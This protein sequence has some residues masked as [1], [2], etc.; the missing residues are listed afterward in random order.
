M[1]GE[2]LEWP[3]VGRSGEL[4]RL[5]RLVSDGETPGV[6][7]AG[8]AGV[9]KTR[10]ALECVRLADKAGLATVRITATRAAAAL[11][12]GALA[13]LLPAGHHGETGGVDDRGDL[14]RRSAAALVERGG[15][16]RLV[17]FLDDAHSLDDASATLIHQLASTNAAFVLATLRVGDPAPEPVVAL[18]KDELV[19]R[20]DLVGLDAGAIEELLSKILGGT[21]D[22]ATVAQL[23]VR[24][25]GNVLFLRELVLGALEDGSLR[26]DGGIWRLAGYPGPSQRLIELVEAR[27]GRL[28]AAG[29]HLL[30]LV[31]YGEPL[32]PAHLEALTDP[33]LAE[34]LERK[35]LL[36]SRLD[37]HRVEVRLA[38]PLYGEVLRSRISALRLP[39]IAR[40]LAE[41]VEGTGARRREDTLRVG[42]WRL[43]GGGAHPELMLTAAITARWRYDFPLAERLAA[44]GVEAG[45]GFDAA[46]LLAQL[47]CL[48]GRPGEAERMLADLAGQATD[49]AQRGLVA[50][51]QLD[52]IG[53]YGGRMDEA[54]KLAEEAESAIADPVWR[55]EITARKAVLVLGCDGPRAA[56]EVVDPLLPTAQGR[57]LAWACL[58]ASFGHGRQGHVKAA[59]DASTLGYATQTSLTQPTD[60]YPLIHLWCRCEA[61][62]HAGRFEEAEALAKEQYALG[63]AEGSG[64]A[65]AWFCWHLASVVGERGNVRTAARYARESIASYRELGRPQF[66]RESLI[67]LALALALGQQA[68][69]ATEALKTLDALELPPTLYKPV[70][71]GLARA[72]TAVAAGDLPG[73]YRLLDEAA[74]LGHRIGDLVGE[75]SALHGLARLGRPTRDVATRL[76]NLAGVIEGNLAPARACHA[77]ALAAGD[78]EGLA[79]AS[80]LFES[81]GAHLLAAEAAADA[82]VTLRKAGDPRK[83]AA[84]ERRA[85]SLA[86]G[87]E[88]A[89]TP[90]LQAGATRAA[91]TSGE[92]QT[93][94]LAAAGRS[95]KQIAEELYVSVRT[96]ENQLQRVYEKLGITS[97][98]QLAEALGTEPSTDPDKRGVQDGVGN[99]G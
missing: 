48:Q 79:Q 88:G 20:I 28:D 39:G 2:K 62:A 51:S 38:H 69:A 31:S 34:E 52:A 73:A 32:G 68:E 65:Q 22:H 98:A 64:E 14:L 95:N 54:L 15:A 25:E 55:G 47:T 23:A 78:P 76:E 8:S 87:C 17:V 18:W 13:A 21:V 12:L 97:R 82:A 53:L 83:A 85:A 60:W 45:A 67:Y 44:A 75:A 72:W 19:P 56:V 37:G 11:P 35:G 9:G 81:M 92:R 77:R 10:L 49:D 80:Q 74:E 36:V 89:F 99:R 46:L 84:A 70:E 41:A 90:G 4:H 3:L 7:I 29:R 33:A 27:L 66:V 43:E 58:I 94:L 26:D 57:A 93:V 30:E 96:V 50:L 1:G 42:T 24:C 91:L 71:L 40:S 59:L 63:L 16:R 86:D 5:R 6:V 61:L